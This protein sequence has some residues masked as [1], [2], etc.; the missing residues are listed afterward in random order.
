M[1]QFGT[2]VDVMVRPPLDEKHMVLFYGKKGRNFR[3]VSPRLK[4]VAR[5]SA[6]FRRLQTGVNCRRDWY[7]GDS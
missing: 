1:G 3:T 7:T 5:L 4:Y 2:V 6:G